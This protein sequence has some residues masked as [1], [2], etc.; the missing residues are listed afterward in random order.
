MVVVVLGRGVGGAKPYTHGNLVPLGQRGRLGEVCFL[1]DL[2][3]VSPSPSHSTRPPLFSSHSLFMGNGGG[4]RWGL[5]EEFSHLVRTSRTKSWSACTGLV[6][7]KLDIWAI[8]CPHIYRWNETETLWVFSYRQNQNLHIHCIHLVILCVKITVPK[9]SHCGVAA[10]WLRLPAQIWRKKKM[11][12]LA[13]VLGV[14]VDIDQASILCSCCY[15]ENDW[16]ATVTTQM[17]YFF[18][19][20]VWFFDCSIW[21]ESTG[22][23]SLPESQKWRATQKD[24]Q[25]I[26]KWVAVVLGIVVK[27]SGSLDKEM[28]A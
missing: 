7:R 19:A 21:Q 1:L 27:S 24:F 2:E 3:N 10:N 6:K 22:G 5:L 17:W 12:Q 23:F 28:K 4:V 15:F 11:F 25:P 9:C 26:E 8:Y 13:S 14:I 16:I 18:L 20:S